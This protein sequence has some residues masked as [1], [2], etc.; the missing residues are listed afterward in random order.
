MKFVVQM[1][2]FRFAPFPVATN[3]FVKKL[4]SALQSPFRLCKTGSHHS[5]LNVPNH[6]CGNWFV[7]KF[8]ARVRTCAGSAAGFV[9]AKEAGFIDVIVRLWV[10][11]HPII[12]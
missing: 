7:R 10:G 2:G 4:F 8:C 12:P 9:R 11:Q 3:S 5:D 6:S 1:L